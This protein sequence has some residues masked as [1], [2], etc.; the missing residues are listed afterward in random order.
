MQYTSNDES[1]IPKQGIPP[2][3]EPRVQTSHLRNT[4]S[5]TH[6]AGLGKNAAML[7]LLMGLLPTKVTLWKVLATFF[8]CFSFQPSLG[9]LN[10][11][12]SLRSKRLIEKLMVRWRF[13]SR[14][15]LPKLLQIPR[16]KL[17]PRSFFDKTLTW[18]IRIINFFLLLAHSVRLF[19]RT[20]ERG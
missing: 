2:C 14:F 7:Q 10:S 8:F 12:F 1:G 3:M 9:S 20:C 6:Y 4:V 18:G 13:T 17:M 19:L 11:V 5:V 15:F 16:K